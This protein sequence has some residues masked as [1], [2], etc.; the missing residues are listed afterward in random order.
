MYWG[1]KQF[2]KTALQHFVIDLG[3][4]DITIGLVYT[5]LFHCDGSITCTLFI[6]QHLNLFLEPTS[7]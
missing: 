5:H 2:I 1:K 3:V 4:C 6:E 7:T